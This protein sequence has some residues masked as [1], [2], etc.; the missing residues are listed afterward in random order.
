[1]NRAQCLILSRDETLR[2]ILSLTL[3]EYRFQPRLAW[4]I[5]MLGNLSSGV[6]TVAWFI[7]LD[8]IEETVEEVTDFARKIAPDAKIVFLCSGFTRELATACLSREATALLVK[9]P[10]VPRLVQT[11]ISLSQE[12]ELLG[13]SEL[14]YDP[15]LS[16][17]E[18]DLPLL[19]G[20]SLIIGEQFRCPVC[21][22]QFHGQK[23]KLWK[24]PVLGID[25]DFFP[26]YSEGICPE[27]YSVV[28]CPEC[29]FAQYIGRFGWF[30][31]EPDLVRGF[32]TE[33]AR[34]ERRRIAKD[35]DFGGER[36]LAAGL[37]SFELAGR[38]CEEL[39]LDDRHRLAGEYFLKMS[40]LCRRQHK[41]LQ[42]QEAQARALECFMY[43]FQPYLTCEGK[44]PDSEAIL[45]RGGPHFQPLQERT[46]VVVGLLAA[47]LS[48][49]LGLRDQAV[50]YFREVLNIPFLA[51]F[52]SLLRH[53]HNTYNRF[54]E[55]AGTD[56]SE[57]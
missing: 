57:L 19:K 12:K 11:I 46:I 28:V 40:W 43:A 13:Q 9:P 55:E 48:R 24:T 22:V 56:A 6:W 16:T 3:K 32:L 14:I 33:D 15:T 51:K 53:A 52:T 39:H 50:Q 1:V 4:S 18:H 23:F 29:L 37:R 25:S 34:A 10:S 42:E 17:A 38:A 21:R 2:T 20:D 5:V 44:F 35:F 26:M 54:Q 30:H 7:D 8:D 49:R 36:P 41:S 31:P 27:L 47:E 45:A